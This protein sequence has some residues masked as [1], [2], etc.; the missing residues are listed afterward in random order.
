MKDFIWSA[1]R[2]RVSGVAWG[3]GCVRCGAARAVWLHDTPVSHPSPRIRVC[4][5]VCAEAVKSCDLCSDFEPAKALIRWLPLPQSRVLPSPVR[6]LPF[7]TRGIQPERRD[8]GWDGVLG[9]KTQSG[10]LL[11]PAQ[12][13]MPARRPKCV[14]ASVQNVQWR[15]LFG[16]RCRSRTVPY[17]PRESAL[18]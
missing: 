16:C 18:P 13:F 1:R 9:G 17:G 11:L 3:Q 4:T 5:P 14:C 2:S 12:P 7:T 8:P 15:T 10:G 6:G